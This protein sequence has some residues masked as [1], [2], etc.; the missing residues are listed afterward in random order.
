M[1]GA[2][3]KS[4]RRPCRGKQSCSTSEAMNLAERS[5]VGDARWRNVNKKKICVLEF[6][7]LKL[8]IFFKININ[9]KWVKSIYFISIIYTVIRIILSFYV[10]GDSVGWEVGTPPDPRPHPWIC[11]GGNLIPIPVLQRKNPQIR[12]LKWGSPREN[13]QWWRDWH[14]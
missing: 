8:G 14:S 10:H 1:G 7:W 11:F 4:G 9:I 2:L 6:E 3:E 5:K 13:T 12:T